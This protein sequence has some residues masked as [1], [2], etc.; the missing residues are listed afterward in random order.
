MEKD[1]V[2]L[3]VVKYNDLRDFK[4]EIEDGFTVVVH[5][6]YVPA[7]NSNLCVQSSAINYIS[8]DEAVQQIGDANVKLKEQVDALQKVIFELND[9]LRNKDEALRHMTVREFRKWRKNAY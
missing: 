3:D 4:K 1:T 2:L 6:Y 5:S 8:T 9:K 7:Y